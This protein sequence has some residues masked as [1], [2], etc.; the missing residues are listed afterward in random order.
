MT[1]LPL[2]FHHYNNHIQVHPLHQFGIKEI[3]RKRVMNIHYETGKV[4]YRMYI[5]F[6]SLKC[7]VEVC[8]DHHLKCMDYLLAFISPFDSIILAI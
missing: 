5:N 1:R 7:E 4:A 6:L 2:S 3:V 8:C